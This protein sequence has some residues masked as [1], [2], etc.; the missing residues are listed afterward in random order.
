MR[1][2]RQQGTTLELLVRKGLHK[3]GLR[4]R[5]ADRRLPGSPDLSFPGRKAVVFV[6]GCFWHGHN[7]RLGGRPSTNTE[8]WTRKA[9]AN[10]ERDARKEAALRTLGWRVFVVWQCELTGKETRERRID[11][12]AGAIRTL[13]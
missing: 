1:Q 5:I 7:C 12:L 11:A 2:V 3:R 4:Y 10:R 8:F 9:E 6:H 13:D